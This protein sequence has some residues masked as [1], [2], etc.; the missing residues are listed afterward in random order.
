MEEKE[1][2]SREKIKSKVLPVWK[3]ILLYLSTFTFYQYYWTYKSWKYL[4]K[5]E[6]IKIS[7]FLRTVLYLFFYYSLAG[8]YKVYLHS[9]GIRS[10]YSPVLLSV[11]LI[12]FILSWRLK[13]PYWIIATFSFFS[14]LPLLNAMNS[15]REKE[16]TGKVILKSKLALLQYIPIS[17]GFG[18]YLFSAL[19]LVLDSFGISV[20]P[21]HKT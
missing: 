4:K 11:T 13:D 18:L 2:Q 21:K 5:E 19:N 15:Y 7:P 1:S 14:Y 3:F 8:R 16:E 20:F 6:N 12:L 17:L 10:N 9:K